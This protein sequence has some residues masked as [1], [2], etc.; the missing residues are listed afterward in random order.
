MPSMISALMPTCWSAIP[1]AAGNALSRAAS[2]TIRWQAGPRSGP[3]C[4]PDVALAVVD[5]LRLGAGDQVVKRSAPV[6]AQESVHHARLEVGPGILQQLFDGPLRLPGTF[7]G[8]G[9]D[10]CVEHIHHGYDGRFEGNLFALEAIGITAAA[11]A[12]MMR[13]RHGTRQI[14]RGIAAQDGIANSRM[15]LY[16]RKFL[17]GEFAR[18]L[19]DIVRGGGPPAPL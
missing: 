9:A 1:W 12:F 11:P 7:V 5:V 6:K 15:V 17:A 2:R 3:S 14:Q 10:Q 16:Q 8:T 19:Q 13:Q 4:A 18:L